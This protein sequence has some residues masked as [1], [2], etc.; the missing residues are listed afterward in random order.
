[1]FRY[2]K[3]AR[4]AV[5][6]MSY[7]MVLEEPYR[8]FF[9]L[10][11]LAGIWGVL[12][13]PLFYGGHLGFYPNEAHARIMIGGFIGAFAV[14]FLGTAFPRLAG[15]RGWAAGEIAVLL[16]CWL[17]AV[18]SW[19]RSMVGAGD[20]AFAACLVVMLAGMAVRLLRGRRDIPPPGFVLVLLGL[21]GTAVS[22]LWLARGPL[23]SLELWRFARLWYFQGFLLLPVMGIGPYLLPRFFGEPSGHSFDTSLKPPAGWWARALAAMV[24]GLCVMA[25]LAVEAWGWPLAG[26][27][28]RAFVVL[29]WFACET[30]VFR[31]PS[32][33]NTP[34]TTVRWSI[35]SLAAGLA[36]AAFWPHA[37]IGSLHLFFV[38]GLGLV[39]MAVGARVILGHAG[40]HDLLG[41]KLV[42]LRWV[43]GLLVL[44][45]ATRMTSDFIPT[46]RVSHHIYAAWTWAAAALVWLLALG[47]YL[48][49]DESAP[50]SS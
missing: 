50:K 42:W 30:P 31:R 6:A 9:P 49:R 47:K 7:G 48:W 4:Q 28:A 16:V 46:V 10:G 13:W 33:R 29:A 23:I 37:R 5:A 3:L 24:A 2:G 36:C 32:Q 14:G 21:A 39:T 44:A 41:G 18:I 40:R 15:V 43:F 19:S 27:L 45:A 22:A 20:E 8:L 11:M 17:L 38:S 34:G 35:V 12:L 1:M 25:T 26:Q